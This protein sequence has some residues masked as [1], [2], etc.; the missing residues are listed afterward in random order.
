MGDDQNKSKK[1]K[2]T[3]KEPVEEENQ[4]DAS[5]MKLSKAE[6]KLMGLNAPGKRKST[7]KPN[8]AKEESPIDPAAADLLKR[9]V[10]EAPT[11]RPSVPKRVE[12]ST[13]D[14]MLTEISTDAPKRDE[15]VEDAKD[16]DDTAKPSENT[17]QRSSWLADIFSGYE[18][19]FP[20]NEPE[21]VKP[22]KVS[23]PPRP[24]RPPQSTRQPAQQARQGATPSTSSTSATIK[25]PAATPSVAAVNGQAQNGWRHGRS[26]G[27]SGQQVPG[28]AAA[29][30]M[31]G[32][33][34][35]QP[36]TPALLDWQC[37]TCGN[38]HMD[39]ESRASPRC[40]QCGELRTPSLPVA[41]VPAVTPVHQAAASAQ[42]SSRAPVTAANDAQ[43]SDDDSS[44]DEPT[45]FQL[46][47]ASQGGPPSQGIQP[48]MFG[49]LADQVSTRADRT[50]AASSA[51]AAV[52]LAA[53][54]FAHAAKQSRRAEMDTD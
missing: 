29:G 52:A 43:D 54:A 39:E 27:V 36:A 22:K 14:S 3:P 24:V 5:S 35:A 25:P 11:V 28:A 13:M 53:Q 10:N 37:M 51:A 31:V 18:S 8:S 21:P 7:T 16:D 48:A 17:Q 1:R 44:S 40:M 30:G 46:A 38:F 23:A 26:S 12:P 32:Q 45:I 41:A 20:Q 19:Q 42:V 15:D 50:H 4:A 2:T 9:L 47:Q 6:R 34:L 49:Q 33:Q